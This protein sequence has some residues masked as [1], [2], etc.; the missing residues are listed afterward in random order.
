MTRC[1]SVGRNKSQ[2]MS[3]QW[4]VTSESIPHSAPCSR[5][6][7]ILSLVFFISWDFPLSHLNRSAKAHHFADAK[8]SHL[9]FQM[10]CP[11]PGETWRD[12]AACRC[13]IAVPSSL[14]PSHSSK[15][16]GFKSRWTMGSASPWDHLQLNYSQQLSCWD[17]LRLWRKLN[18]LATACF[19]CIVAALLIFFLG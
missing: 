2:K 9:H 8:I 17:K 3:D 18:A 10:L 11:E 6:L 12:M 5:S 19:L 7:T 4:P 1:K 13:A 16:K 14:W 15:F